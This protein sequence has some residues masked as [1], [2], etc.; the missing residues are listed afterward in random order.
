[1]IIDLLIL[2]YNLLHKETLIAFTRE[3]SLRVIGPKINYCDV[4]D[5][6][7]VIPLI[8][9]IWD[10]VLCHCY[11]IGFGLVDHILSLHNDPIYVILIEFWVLAIRTYL[12]DRKSQ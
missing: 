10:M 8:S 3:I 11:N 7:D 1:M 2:L 9:K 6:Q 4:T 12:N 5:H